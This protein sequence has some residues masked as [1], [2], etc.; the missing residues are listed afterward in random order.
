MFRA[1]ALREVGFYGDGNLKY[2]EDYNLAVKMADAGYG[3]VYSDILLAEYRVW[4]DVN[5][6]RP[7]RKGDQLQAYIWIYR[8][9]LYDAFQKRGWDPKLID[10]FRKKMARIH[11]ASCFSSIFTEREQ[12]ELITLL[13]ELGD[14]PALRLRLLALSWGFAPFFSWQL[15]TSL[16][17]KGMVKDFLSRL[18]GLLNQS[19]EVQ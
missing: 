5:H 17:L 19:R 11:A 6:V 10:R 18:K 3:N 4:H 9:T 14:S 8:R 12:E 2:S 15:D 7:K 16:K 1:D 13:K